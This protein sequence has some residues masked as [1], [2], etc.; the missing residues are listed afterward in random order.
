MIFHSPF[1]ILQ[2]TGKAGNGHMPQLPAPLTL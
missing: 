1:F 2:D